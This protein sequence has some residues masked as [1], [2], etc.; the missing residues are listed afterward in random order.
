MISAI[1]QRYYQNPVIVTFNPTEQEMDA[2]PFPAVTICN[3]NP[4]RRSRVDYY[5]LVMHISAH[6]MCISTVK[7]FYSIC[8]T[9]QKNI[10]RS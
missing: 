7:G 4:F 10:Y 8:I 2:I 6:K 1:W 3:M 9:L 5:L